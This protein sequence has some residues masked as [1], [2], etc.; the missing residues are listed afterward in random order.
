[1]SA[2]A[3]LVISIVSHGHGPEL[4]PLLE[5]LAGLPDGER[6]QRVVLTQNVPEAEPGAPAGGWPFALQ[7]VRNPSPQGFGANHNQALR[8][9]PEQVFCVLNPDVRLIPGENALAQLCAAAVQ[10]GVG[11]AYPVQVDA[12]GRV[13]DSER[14]LPT[15]QALWRRRAL[16]RAE[17]Q[18][19][20]VNAACMVLPRKAWEQV[21]GFDTGYFMYCEDVDLCLRLQLAGWRLQRVP[22]R[23]V[24][25]GQRASSRQ[26]RHLCWHLQ[27]LGRLWTSASYRQWRALREPQ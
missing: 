26:W 9:A 12:A 25:A 6:P 21:G 1:M 23:M 8:D 7:L 17:T 20:W 10:D 11:C 15:P 3:S 27:A 16:G 4:Q 24:H 18:V 22:A 5:Q 14:A 13:Q 2:S 19:D